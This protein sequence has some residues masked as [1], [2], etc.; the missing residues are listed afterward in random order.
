MAAGAMRHRSIRT[1]FLSSLAGALLNV[2]LKF[3]PVVKV[4]TT[5]LANQV[6]GHYLLLFDLSPRREMRSAIAAPLRSIE[7]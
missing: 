5:F 2:F 3:L 1:A 7:L 6:I 4:L